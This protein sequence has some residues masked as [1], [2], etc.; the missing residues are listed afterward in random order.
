M[1]NGLRN[2][3]LFARPAMPQQ[4]KAEAASKLN[5]Y[6]AENFGAEH[7]LP[8]ITGVSEK[9]IAYAES[10]RTK[11][12]SSDLSGC[13]VKLSRFFAVEDK[14][15]LEN[16]SEEGRAAAEKQAEAEGLSVEAWFAKNRPAIVAR[17]SKISF[18]DIVK[19]IEVIVNESNASKIIDALR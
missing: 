18:V 7:P 12:I 6:I 4:K 8:K 19:K 1:Q 11:F 3:L 2:T 14:T 17:T 15:R 16:M 5:A 10:L 9:Q 13:N